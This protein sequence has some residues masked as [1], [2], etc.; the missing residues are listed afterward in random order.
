MGI[1]KYHA[2]W[3]PVLEWKNTDSGSQFYNKVVWEFLRPLGRIK[4]VWLF[5]PSMQIISLIFLILLSLDELVIIAAFR[6]LCIFW[7][8]NIFTSVI[9]E[10]IFFSHNRLSNIKPEHLSSWPVKLLFQ[11]YS[12]CPVTKRTQSVTFPSNSPTDWNTSCL[13]TLHS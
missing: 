1:C 5:F 4:R 13:R 3:Q 6:V 8:C 2:I 7:A 11:I 9:W 12:I 10:I